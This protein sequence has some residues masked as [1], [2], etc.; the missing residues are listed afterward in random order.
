MGTAYKIF[1][2][3]NVILS[4]PEADACTVYSAVGDKLLFKARMKLI[5]M[6]RRIH[7]AFALIF[8][9]C[10]SI[11]PELQRRAGYHSVFKRLLA[12]GLNI[13]K[14]LCKL[15]YCTGSRKIMTC[16]FRKFSGFLFC[17]T[18]LEH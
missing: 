16:I 5:H 10:Q 15:F 12:L 7:K 18:K 8:R 14:L 6:N 11:H 17:L 9:Q 4:F 13:L 1:V 2:E 3:H